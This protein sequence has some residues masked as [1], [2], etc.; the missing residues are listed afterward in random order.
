MNIEDIINILGIAVKLLNIIVDV[1]LHTAQ[2]YK[3]YK[4]K[5]RIKVEP[6]ASCTSKAV[7]VCVKRKHK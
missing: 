4:K 5:H 1:I 6:P 3:S 7:R 2:S